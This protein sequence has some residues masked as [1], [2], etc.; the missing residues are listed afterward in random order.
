MVGVL[1]GMGPAATADFYAKL[2]RATPAATDQ[3][4]LRVV[5]WSDPT[6]PDR[7]RALLNG[8]ED[9][10]PAM[11]DGARALAAMG[12][13]IIAIP[14]N[15]AHAFLPQVQ[16]QVDVPFVH[17][18]QETAAHIAC[19]HPSARVAG[20]LSTTGTQRARLYHDALG[21]RDIEVLTP[22]PDAQRRVMRAIELVKAG[23]GRPRAASVLG[24]VAG[25]LIA[26]GAQVLI[27]GCTEI[28]LLLSNSMLPVPLVDPA[29]VLA[30]AVV[31]RMRCSD[32]VGSQSGCDAPRSR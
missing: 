17:M 9:P 22:G 20:L 24:R 5:I 28:P 32:H 31:R 3:E 8:G 23:A 27:A 2:V 29:Q 16:G 4:H 12:A 26:D 15:T 11:V 18:V 7:T 14:C 10:T 1:G 25:E 30:E 6:I 19:A 21:N 13:V